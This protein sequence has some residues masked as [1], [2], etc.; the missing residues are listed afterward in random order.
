MAEN[1]AKM[2]SFNFI[3]ARWFKPEEILID[4]RYFEDYAKMRGGTLRGIQD[5]VI[6]LPGNYKCFLLPDKPPQDQ[7]ELLTKENE[8][9]L[10]KFHNALK[11]WL[12]RESKK[13]KATKY[14]AFNKP[15]NQAFS[16]GG[17]RGALY[18]YFD[19]NNNP[20]Y[21][22]GKAFTFAY[23]IVA[24]PDGFLASF[25]IQGVS[26]NANQILNKIKSFPLLKNSKLS[27]E[28]FKMFKLIN[29][30]HGCDGQY[31][32]NVVKLDFEKENVHFFE[33]L[34]EPVDIIL[35]I[36]DFICNLGSKL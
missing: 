26:D 28:K 17:K 2:G 21:D 33:K 10:Q 24:Q 18:G 19:Y 12:N 32:Q 22:K 7:S 13:C 29:K 4:L 27:G 15:F 36:L 3:I 31:L 14:V 25:G 23:S 9:A 8:K 34:D 1:F 11:D 35:N 30:C 20:K 5:E 16:Y 6:V